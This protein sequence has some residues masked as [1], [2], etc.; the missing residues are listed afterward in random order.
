MGWLPWR[1]Q[2]QGGDDGGA[3]GS[4]SEPAQSGDGH[5]AHAGAA[6]AGTAAAAAA[7]PL[8]PYHDHHQRQ[9][10]RGQQQRGAPPPP[11]A[12]PRPHQQQQAPGGGGAASAGAGGS[13]GGAGKDCEYGDCFMQ[14]VQ[15]KEYCKA[16]FSA[17]DSCFDGV[18]GGAKREEDCMPLVRARERGRGARGARAQRRRAAPGCS[19]PGPPPCAAALTSFPWERCPPTPRPQFDA[20][21]ACM[22]KRLQVDGIIKEAMG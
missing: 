20:F 8:P 12:Q 1:R 3:A 16:E 9:Q 18:E 21:R 11:Q 6:P 14:L 2:R 13:G 5:H 22:K 7:L 19:R 15:E 10:Q 17:F 4:S